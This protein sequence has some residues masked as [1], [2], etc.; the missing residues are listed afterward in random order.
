MYGLCDSL[1]ARCFDNDNNHVQKKREKKIENRQVELHFHVHVS[2][3]M[4]LH[5][6]K[7]RF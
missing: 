6:A 1:I 4:Q 2:Q 5:A 7:I 3:Y